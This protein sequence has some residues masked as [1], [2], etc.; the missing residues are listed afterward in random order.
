MRAEAFDEFVQRTT[1]SLLGRARALTTDSHDAWDLVQETLARLGERWDRI[2]D[3]AAYASTVM[4]RLN[5][6]RIRRLRRDLTLRQ[7]LPRPGSVP[8][9]ADGPDG[10]LLDALQ[11]LSPHQRTALA[12]RY[13]DDLDVEAIAARFGCRPGTARSHLSRGLARL[14][15]AAPTEG[16]AAAQWKEGP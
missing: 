7:R 11:T 16:L 2:D 13:L 15:A 14:R 3:P 9:P 5:I 12:L 10:W 4:T 1:P 6:D 8:P